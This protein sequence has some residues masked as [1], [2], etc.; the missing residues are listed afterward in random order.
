MGDQPVVSVVMAVHDGERFL[1]EAVESVLGQSFTDFE[2]II[3][4]DGSKDASREI[5]ASYDD[6]RIRII[7]NTENIGL[8]RSLNVGLTHVAGQFVAR[9]DAD[10]VSESERLERQLIFLRSHPEVGLVGTHLKVIDESGA[11][12]YCIARESNRDTLRH[13]VKGDSVLAHGTM[14]IRRS[15]LDQ[16]GGYDEKIIKAQDYDLALRISEVSNLGLVPEVL[17]R[18]RNWGDSISNTVPDQQSSYV[19][20]AKRKARDR[21]LVTHPAG[22]ARQLPEDGVPAFSV[23]MANYNN[24]AYLSAAIESVIDQT[25]ENW[26]LLIC[27]DASSD[28][29]LTVIEPYLSDPRIRLLQND[30]NLGYVG[31]LNRMLAESRGEYIGILD[32]DDALTYD[33]LER[34]IEAHDAHPEASFVYS[35]FLVCNEQ[36][37]TTKVGY[38]RALREGETVLSADCASAFRTWK[39]WA[40]NR[41]G[42]FTSE[43]IY[44]EDKDFI[45]R[46]ETVGS[47]VYV[48]EA[49]YYA[50][51]LK[52]SQS[53]GSRFLLARA[54][55]HM[56]VIRSWEQ[57]L[58]TDLP[59]ISR[60]EAVNRAWLGLGLSLRK[61]SV[62]HVLRFA[63]WLLRHP[64]VGV[65]HMKSFKAGLNGSWSI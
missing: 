15:V 46:M 54:S 30:R 31:A 37:R 21:F 55:H 65:G 14:M 47:L 8:T 16:V 7:D 23:I 64:G 52:E 18:W 32:S 24:A 4:N 56:A 63:V 11:E 44:A 20:M 50:R 49:L 51:V 17:Y 27:D 5:L 25:A 60:W 45:F 22:R 53:H 9:Q 6:P 40:S 3:V 41:A 48:D 19:A 34:M 36:L 26:E 39:R 38:C 62:P 35:Q 2:F 29:S 33:A 57:R 43:M 59:S 61:G 10:D 42:G 12:L 1:R 13:F 58:A 28:D